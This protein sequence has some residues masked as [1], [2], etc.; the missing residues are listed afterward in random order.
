MKKLL[1][2]LAVSFIIHLSSFIILFA[3]P[4]LVCDP[5]PDESKPTRFEMLIDG[6]AQQTPY[7]LHSTGA[8]IVLDVGPLTPG[9]HYITD[10]K[11]CNARGCSDPIPF[12]I[13][14]APGAL[15]GPRL[16]H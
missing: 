12:T 1:L 6:Q 10:L 5:Y 3:A 8:A 9:A 16:E 11:A 14:A 2:I 7:A 15:S 4:Y 13:P